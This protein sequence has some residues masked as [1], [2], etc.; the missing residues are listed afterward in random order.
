MRRGYCEGGEEP[1]GE[2]AEAVGT[3]DGGRGCDGERLF[4]RARACPNSTCG[5]SE[6]FKGEGE[7]D[8][9]KVARAKGVRG[10]PFTSLA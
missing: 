6:D 7:V 8:V 5:R 10:R 3:V 2:E 9:K 4:Y 1:T